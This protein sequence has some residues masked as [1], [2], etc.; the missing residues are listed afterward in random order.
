MASSQRANAKLAAAAA[1]K[2]AA[3]P[4]VFRSFPPKQSVTTPRPTRT[5]P[6][7]IRTPA[8]KRR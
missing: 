5:A 6:P 4:Y 8:H 2:A 1:R 3:H 7:L